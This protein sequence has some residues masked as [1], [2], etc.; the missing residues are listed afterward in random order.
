MIFD[1][2]VAITWI[3]Y[4]ALFPMA[5]FWWRRAY[6]I[7]VKRDFSEVALKRGESPP[8]PEKYAPYAMIINLIAGVVAAVVIV[9]VALGQL[10]LAHGFEAGQ[11]PDGRKPVQ[12]PVLAAGVQATT[13]VENPVR[14]GCDGHLGDGV[15][16]GLHRDFQ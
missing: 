10:V 2:S 12:R 1:V 6:R 5:F 7:L 13:A 15:Q 9:S 4:L 3:L 11:D 14:I 8:D 16:K